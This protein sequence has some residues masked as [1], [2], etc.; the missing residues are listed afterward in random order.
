MCQATIRGHEARASGP[1]PPSLPQSHALPRPV[2]PPVVACTRIHPAQRP[3]PSSFHC[4][5]PNRHPRV[6]NQILRLSL[7]SH[8][9]TPRH[10]RPI[11]RAILCRLSRRTGGTRQRCTLLARPRLC[12]KYSSPGKTQCAKYYRKLGRTPSGQIPGRLSIRSW[13]P[14]G[15]SLIDLT[16]H[17][18]QEGL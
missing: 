7:Q 15:R 11:G 18:I 12:M 9:L 5:S 13:A 6:L 14:A 3:C 10:L 2:S 17:S 16:G 8:S 1:Q 4:H